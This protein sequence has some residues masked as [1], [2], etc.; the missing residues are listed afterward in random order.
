MTRMDGPGFGLC[1]APLES[2]GPGFLDVWQRSDE[3]AGVGKYTR[4]EFVR[5]DLESEG[6]S[7]DH[8]FSWGRGSY[9]VGNL[10]D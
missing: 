7:Q 9:W 4:L 6:R 1:A 2:S 8:Q 3:R 5:G 10:G